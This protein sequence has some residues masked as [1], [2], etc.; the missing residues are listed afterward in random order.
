MC[1][2][3]SKT[4][5]AKFPSKETLEIC[6]NNNPDGAGY[7]FAAN[8]KVHIRKGFMKFDDFWNSLQSVRTKYGDKIACVMHFR[9]GTQGGNI[10]ANTHPFPLSRKMD[11]LRKL[12]YSTDVG[13]AHNGIIDLTTTYGQKVNYSDTMKFI[14]DYLTLIITKENKETWFKSKETCKLIEKLIESRFSVMQKDGHITLLGEGW[15]KDD[16]TGVWYSNTSWKAPKYKAPKDNW[17]DYG[18]GYEWDPKTKSYVTAT[19]SYDEWDIYF[20]ETSGQ[21]DF[22]ETYCPGIMEG[23][24]EYCSMCA[25]RGKCTFYKEYMDSLFGDEEL[26]K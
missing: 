15:N 18:W 3:A 10:P 26:N 12:N 21:Y 13:I 22:D 2:I 19:G 5:K 25:N 24:D 16:S 4:S 1:V 20:D 8:N 6:W 7:M 17:N 11:N 14:T 9:I 23:S